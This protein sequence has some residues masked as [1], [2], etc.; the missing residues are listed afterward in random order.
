MSQ[1]DPF[2]AGEPRAQAPA[3]PQVEAEVPT[4]PDAQVEAEETS[5]DADGDTEV[6]D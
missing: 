4:E 2:A 5:E 1:T 6:P 3:E